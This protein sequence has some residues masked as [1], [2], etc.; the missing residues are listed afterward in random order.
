MSLATVLL[1]LAF[2]ST[3][4]FWMVVQNG[5]SCLR[6][7]SL[8]KLCDW[9]VSKW[10]GTPFR[11]LGRTW[12]FWS[13]RSRARSLTLVVVFLYPLTRADDNCLLFAGDPED[14]WS[15]RSHNKTPFSGGWKPLM[16]SGG[17]GSH[18]T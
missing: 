17:Q 13:S 4:S 2:P 6:G 5:Q 18:L 9:R 16:L 3:S 7:C 11:A 12:E 14:N 1:V 8:V 15:W 10:T